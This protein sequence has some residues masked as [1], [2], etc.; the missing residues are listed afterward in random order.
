M[1]RYQTMEANIAELVILSAPQENIRSLNVSFAC[2]VVSLISCRHIK[3][4][5]VKS[6]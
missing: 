1:K 2:F 6:I 3:R 4:K 5:Q